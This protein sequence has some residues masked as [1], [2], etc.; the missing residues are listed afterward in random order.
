MTMADDTIS[1]PMTGRTL[2]LTHA[3]RDARR[4]AEAAAANVGD[5]GPWNFDAALLA[6]DPGTD[7]ARAARA[8]GV[9]A[10][11]LY[12]RTW[13]LCFPGEG[14]GRRRTVMAIAA[15][16]VL[17]RAGYQATVHYESD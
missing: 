9:E 12:K 15:A 17:T 1:R 16:Q 3:L 11:L 7:V 10:E 2:A 14:Q 13:N 6:A 4:A 5:D 8:V